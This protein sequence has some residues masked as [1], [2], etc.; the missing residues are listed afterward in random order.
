MSKPLQSFY[1]ATKYLGQFIGEKV[2]FLKE[3]SCMSPN[4]REIMASIDF[5]LEFWTKEN[6]TEMIEILKIAKSF[7]EKLGYARWERDTVTDMALKKG[8][9]TE[10]EDWENDTTDIQNSEDISKD[11]P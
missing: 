5:A 1:E 7:L 11:S 9:P 10:K 2:P 3:T 6:D 8:S 4:I